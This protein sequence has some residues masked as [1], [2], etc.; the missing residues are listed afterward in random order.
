MVAGNSTLGKSQVVGVPA[1]SAQSDALR[2]AAPDGSVEV[3]FLLTE[4][5]G[6]PPMP[7]P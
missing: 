7:C 4:G 5:E 3:G 6:A 1:Q 2:L